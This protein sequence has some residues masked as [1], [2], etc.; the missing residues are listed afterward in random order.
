VLRVTSEKLVLFSE[1][2]WQIV[3]V[4]HFMSDSRYTRAG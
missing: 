1:L 2:N 4:G 3:T